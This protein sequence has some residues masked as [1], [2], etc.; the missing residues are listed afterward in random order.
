MMKF[1][2]FG[3][4]SRV[5]G[6]AA[7]ALAFAAT[8][9]AAQAGTHPMS[10]ASDIHVHLDIANLVTGDIGPFASASG[11][12]N[13]TTP[14]Y[15]NHQ[16]FLT[17]A[18]S[19]HA[20]AIGV[21]VLSG[22]GLTTKVLSASASGGPTSATATS[23][24]E[25]LNLGLDLLGSSLISFG[26]RNSVISST[27]TATDIGGVLSVAGSSLLTGLTLNVLGDAIDLSAYANAAPNTVLA[28]PT[29]LLGLT[30]TL[31]KQT[32]GHPLDGLS[33]LTDAIDINFNHLHLAGLPL[34]HVVSGDITIGESFAAIPEP[35]VWMEMLMGAGMIGVLMRR[36]RQR[37][38][39]ATVA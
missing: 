35:A 1:R 26:G 24:I 2:D 14:T 25:G 36:S 29:N 37:T 11:V 31:N 16:T 34:N 6:L 23:R 30:I 4:L 38:A 39:N 27:S 22:L 20:T 7:A 28:L 17:A 12:S 5:V 8:A 33:I 3:P 10:N 9:P 19:G 21:P 13:L 32:I 18:A 15:N